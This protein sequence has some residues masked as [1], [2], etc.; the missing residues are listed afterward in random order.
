V[1][2][3]WSNLSAFICRSR[4]KFDLS[5]A[6]ASSILLYLQPQCNII[7]IPTQTCSTSRNSACR[8][9]GTHVQA[10]HCRAQLDEVHEARLL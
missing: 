8:H 4:I 6:K 9:F 10:P 7:Q 5:A 2:P 1:L 3:K